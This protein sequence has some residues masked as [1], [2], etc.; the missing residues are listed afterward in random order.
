MYR[1]LFNLSDR[2]AVVT[3]ASKGLGRSIAMALAGAGA[4]VAL[5]AGNRDDLE[6][7]KASILSL[8]RRAEVFCVD[9]LDVKGVD[10]AVKDT[11][12]FFGHVDILVNN[13]G[14]NII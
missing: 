11:L 13:A 10:E 4:D 9:V 1:D 2:V 12:D 3:G 6:A 14:V 7:V 5:Y 8:G